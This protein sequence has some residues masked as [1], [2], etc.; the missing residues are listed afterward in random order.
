MKRITWLLA[1]VLLSGC[2]HLGISDPDGNPRDLWNQAHQALLV[3]DFERASTLFARLADEYPMAREGRESRFYL[4]A[5]RLDPRNRA[6]DPAPAERQ[7]RL[8]LA[9]DSPEDVRV[10]RRPEAEV[11]LQLASQL[12][13][14]AEQRVPGLQPET[15]VVRV[16][17]RVVVP[18]RE[19]RALAAQVESLRRELEARDAQ[20]R[21]QREELE[22]IRKTLTGTK[23]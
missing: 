11:L 16:P 15:R 22:R 6:W 14:P 17:Q 2:A 18:A 9:A 4:G 20:I 1:L 12:N 8:Y 19:S 13:M 23:R 10:H 7:L 21:Q 5:I 3:E